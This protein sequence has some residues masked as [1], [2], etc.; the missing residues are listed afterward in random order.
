MKTVFIGNKERIEINAQ[1][2]KVLRGLG[3]PEPPLNLD[4]VRE[5][6]RLDRQYYSTTDTSALREFASKIKIGAK[7]LFENPI[8]MWKIVQK[9]GLKALWVPA[10]RRILIDKDQPVKKHRW[11][12]SHEISHAI[13]E[14]HQAFLFGDSSIELSISCQD[15]LEAEANYGAGQLLF[16]RDR[17]AKEAMQ[18]EMSM[19]TVKLLHHRFDNSYTCT[20][21]RY[22][23]QL[24]QKLPILGLVTCHPKQIPDGHD[25]AA[26]CK[27]FIESSAFRLQ[28]EN[29][30]EVE[31]FQAITRYCKNARGGT[32]GQDE[33]VLRDV[34]GDAHVFLFETFYN[35]YEALTLAYYVRKHSLIIPAG[36]LAAF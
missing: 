30:S 1:V 36:A 16:L 18:L 12:E 9:A 20:L 11:S 10:P 26:P 27:Y 33:I 23:E 21:W 14:W 4:L 2:E 13:T 3:N 29:V 8:E 19:A 34:N 31:V 32:L 7:Q 24:G 28:F 17:F 5:L 35:T 6:L 15:Q 25:M 22:V